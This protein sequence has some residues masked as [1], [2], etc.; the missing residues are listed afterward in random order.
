[1]RRGSTNLGD[2]VAD[3][4]QQNLPLND[5]DN[6]APD[7]AAA[8]EARARAAEER[9]AKLE[10]AE[11]KRK[12]D[13]AAAKKAA[14]DKDAAARGEFERLA[15]EKDA[16]LARR[17]EEL[18]ALRQ[19]QIEH[20]DGLIAKL[21][22]NSKA[23]VAAVREDLPLPKLLKFVEAELADTQAPPPGSP[24]PSAPP[25][26][27]PGKTPKTKG[28]HELQAASYEMVERLGHDPSKMEEMASRIEDPA[29]GKYKFVIPIGK[30]CKR[31]KDESVRP[32][33]M[34]RAGL[35]DRSGK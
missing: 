33:P 28:K 11:K 29:T 8:A 31:L 21:P 18:E 4:N 9:A 16:E 6:K 7:A 2:T 19:S 22:D 17:N 1:M 32:A 26:T 20:I 24:A 13:E 12:A 34:T 3:D 14:A 5:D 10:A 15:A 25:P 30:M 23:K 27:S 35:E